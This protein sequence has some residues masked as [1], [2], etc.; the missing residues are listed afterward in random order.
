MSNDGTKVL[1]EPQQVATVELVRLRASKLNPRKSFPAED[2]EE[3]AKSIFTHGIIE[4]LIVR[5]HPDGK[6]FEIVCGERR[7]RA[8]KLAKL[9]AV[10]VVV[11]SLDDD[12]VRESMLIENIQ[13][14]DLDPVDEGHAVAELLKA[15]TAA[16]VGVLLG[17]KRSWVFARARLPK[18]PKKVIELAKAGKLKASHL[19]YIAKFRTPEL[20]EDMAFQVSIG[21]IDFEELRKVDAASAY[22]DASAAWAKRMRG[23]GHRVRAV[24][25]LDHFPSLGRTEQKP[26]K[27]RGPAKFKSTRWSAK[28]RTIPQSKLQK[29]LDGTCARQ[30][31]CVGLLY[32]LVEPSR[33]ANQYNPAGPAPK[34]VQF[35]WSILDTKHLNE[36]VGDKKDGQSGESRRYQREDEVRQANRKI[37]RVFSDQIKKKLKA[38]LPK[39]DGGLLFDCGWADLANSWTLRNLGIVAPKKKDPAWIVR[40]YGLSDVLG[41]IHDWEDKWWTNPIVRKLAKLLGVEMPK[42]EKSK[43]KEASLGKR[44]KKTG[45]KK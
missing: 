23:A 30:G 43:K 5:D 8:A 14:E 37:A 35:A 3:L 17:K 15:R 38:G 26:K 21:S 24:T 4:P 22:V 16:E 25:Y 29:C 6:G 11:R 2:I 36:L 7:W 42:K 41:E 9:H 31:K 10:P 28:D 20:Q 33:F 12:A 40:V 44:R 45:S 18:M 13:R 19:E 1:E 27:A 34:G 39:N 32:R